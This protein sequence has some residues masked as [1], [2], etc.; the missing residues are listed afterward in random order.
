MNEEMH[1]IGHAS[2]SKLLIFETESEQRLKKYD[3]PPNF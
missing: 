2:L 1:N 3:E